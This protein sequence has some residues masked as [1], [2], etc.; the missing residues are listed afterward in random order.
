MTIMGTEG[1]NAGKTILT[2]FDFPDAT[3]M[4]VCYDLTGAAFPSRF[5]STAENGLFL[6]IYERAK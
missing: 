3:R 6:V 1:P 5:E 4:R 2:I